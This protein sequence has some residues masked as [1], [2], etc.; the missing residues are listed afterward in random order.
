[1][2]EVFFFADKQT[3]KH[4]GQKLYALDIPMRGHKKRIVPENWSLLPLEKI[5][6]KDQSVYSCN[7]IRFGMHTSMIF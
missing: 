7:L 3:D 2:K 5:V 1:M 4:T 6:D